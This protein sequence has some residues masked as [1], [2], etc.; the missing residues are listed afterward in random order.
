MASSHPRRKTFGPA[1][2]WREWSR[3]R[4]SASLT[5]AL[6]LH[7]AHANTSNIMLHY[8]NAGSRFLG[9]GV[10][11]ACGEDLPNQASRSGKRQSFLRRLSPPAAVRPNG[12]FK[13]DAWTSSA[14]IRAMS[15]VAL[16]QRAPCSLLTSRQVEVR[17]PP[18]LRYCAKPSPRRRVQKFA[19]DEPPNWIC[20]WLAVTSWARTTQPHD[21]SDRCR[22]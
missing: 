10:S 21:T 6:V 18:H 17:S 16:R 11:N 12:H 2:Q 13:Q 9:T 8:L 15:P 1:A 20:I 4:D 14:A 5:G 19:M 7:A 22:R 3:E